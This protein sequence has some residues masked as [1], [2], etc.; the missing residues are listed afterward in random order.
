MAA[1]VAGQT[2]ADAVIA[3]QIAYYRARA[4]EYDQSMLELGRYI[5]MGGSV[6]GRP[7]CDDGDARSAPFW[8]WSGTAL[9]RRARFSSIEA[10]A[11]GEPGGMKPPL[12]GAA[13]LRGLEAG[14]QSRVVRVF[15]EPAELEAKLRAL[16]WSMEV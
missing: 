3:D 10:S 12:E 11:T 8:Q 6:A 4:G 15:Y 2:G 7:G 5:S 9:A 13:A 14:G 1:K 16:G